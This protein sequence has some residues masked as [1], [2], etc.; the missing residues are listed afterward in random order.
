MNNQLK[1]K[2]KNDIVSRYTPYYTFFA[3][4][5]INAGDIVHS[6]PSETLNEVVTG[7]RVLK[8]TSG[9]FGE[10]VYF[11]FVDAEDVGA[12]RN[13]KAQGRIRDALAK[14]EGTLGLLPNP[15]RS[16]ADVPILIVSQEAKLAIQG[17]KFE[18]GAATDRVSQEDIPANYLQY[19]DPVS[20]T[21]KPVSE[22]KQDEL[23]KYFG[24]PSEEAQKRFEQL[25]SVSESIKKLNQVR[26]TE[27]ENLEL[28]FSDTLMDDAA[29]LSKLNPSMNLNVDAAA[30]TMA[31]DSLFVDSG[32]LELF[33]TKFRN[34]LKLGYPVEVARVIALATVIDNGGRYGEEVEV[35]VAPTTPP[36]LEIGA[37]IRMKCNSPCIFSPGPGVTFGQMHVNLIRDEIADLGSAPLFRT[38]YILKDGPVL[39]SDGT[40]LA[41]IMRKDMFSEYYLEQK[42]IDFITNRV[43]NAVRAGVWTTPDMFRQRLRGMND[44]E[45]R[46]FIGEIKNYN[47]E[48]LEAIRYE[49]RSIRMLRETSR[50]KGN[51]VIH[52][53]DA[54]AARELFFQIF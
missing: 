19:F 12:L 51:L 41:D 11:K 23:Q 33:R 15:G 32:H 25:E 52:K 50:L 22:Y 36:V 5:S 34:F 3:V 37:E 6:T 26:K 40:I 46:E 28:S 20:G 45:L 27:F 16:G 48:I 53:T 8:A 35:P 9:L 47:P 21:L 13:A 49:P 42:D 17:I 44:E 39:R 7:N 38:R 43:R 31:I 24:L 14:G 30:Q 2:W 4:D 54:E 1:K 29:K 18:E 10:G